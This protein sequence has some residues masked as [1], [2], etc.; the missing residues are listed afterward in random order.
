MHRILWRREYRILYTNKIKKQNS[1]MAS[2]GS[3]VHNYSYMKWG[4]AEWTT[5]TLSKGGKAINH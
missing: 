5:K 1:N 2:P 3:E 4:Y